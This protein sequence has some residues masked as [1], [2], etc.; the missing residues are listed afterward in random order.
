MAKSEHDEIKELADLVCKDGFMHKRRHHE[1]R[2]EQLLRYLAAHWTRNEAE[3]SKNLSSATVASKVFDR[4][5]LTT[6]VVNKNAALLRRNLEYF[7]QFTKPGRKCPKKLELPEGSPYV[8]MLSGNVQ[9]LDAVE[10]FWDAHAINGIEN[11]LAYT[12]PIVFYDKKRRCYIRYLDINCDSLE[13]QEV[14]RAVGEN[15]GHEALALVPDFH[16][17]AS[18]EVQAAHVIEAWFKKNNIVIEAGLTRQV[19]SDRELYTHNSILLGSGRANRHIREFQRD[20]GFRVEKDRV[21]VSEADPARGEKAEYVEPEVSAHRTR[22]FSHCVVTRLPN[23]VNEAFVT[24]IAANNGRAIES[25]AI[26]LTSIEKMKELY[27]AY[28]E[29]GREGPLPTRFQIIFRVGIV[30]S[31]T[32]V[33]A[34]QPIA[35]RVYPAAQADAAVGG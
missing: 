24:M 19:T 35:L 12:E 23:L 1:G 3:A 4:K 31:P 10:R 17:Q 20:L 13:A 7:F 6:N 26:Y 28:L 14:R 16:Y 27:Q 18:G 33:D 32:L 29:L 15:S 34:A 22:E 5:D 30:H 9:K 8:L 21:V 11:R 2:E 25:V